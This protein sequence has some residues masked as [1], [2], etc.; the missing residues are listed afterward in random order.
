MVEDLKDVLDARLNQVSKQRPVVHVTADD[1]LSFSQTPGEI[2]EAGLR[3]NISV[4]LQYIESWLM[5]V[6]AAAIF[7]LMEDAA[8]AEISRSQIWQWIQ[9]GGKL[10]DGR[11]VTKDLV[12]QLM[13]E[14]LARLP[15]EDAGRRFKEA[16]EIFEEVSLSDEFVD[17][18]TIPAYDYID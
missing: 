17:F 9:H 2:T 4:G 15:S 11:P 16:H 8:T 6:G 7:N 5:G 10:N 14:E 1:L 18:L 12:R 13:Q 3:Q